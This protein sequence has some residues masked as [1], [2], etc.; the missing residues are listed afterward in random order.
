[1]CLSFGLLS[2][3]LWI[4]GSHVTRTPDNA[5]PRWTCWCWGFPVA[6]IFF[7]SWAYPPPLI[8]GGKPDSDNDILGVPQQNPVIN[9]ATSCSVLAA[10]SVG[11]A[12]SCCRPLY[13]YTLSNLLHT[14]CSSVAFQTSTNSLAASE[15]W[16]YILDGLDWVGHDVIAVRIVW[17]SRHLVR[18][19]YLS[20]IASCHTPGRYLQVWGLP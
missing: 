3:W 11:L 13:A 17:A 16:P 20:H 15:A 6:R 18:T 8:C 14:A 9:P 1:M 2:H 5:W 12:S 19:F 10:G 7:V 4:M